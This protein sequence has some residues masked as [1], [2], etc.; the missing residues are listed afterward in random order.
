MP[1]RKM[2][3]MRAL[4][5]AKQMRAQNRMEMGDP[6]DRS[7]MEGFDPVPG[8]TPRGYMGSDSVPISQLSQAELNR[9][10]ISRRGSDEALRRMESSAAFPESD[11]MTGMTDSEAFPESDRTY[12]DRVKARAQ[13]LQSGKSMFDPKLLESIRGSTD[14]GNAFAETTAM[15][16]PERFDARDSLDD[17]PGLFNRALNKANEIFQM[18]GSVPSGI[19]R[20]IGKLDALMNTKKSMEAADDR[21]LEMSMLNPLQSGF[22]GRMRGVRQSLRDASGDRLME[23]RFA[24][25]VKA[26]SQLP[27]M[28]E[29]MIARDKLRGELEDGFIDRQ[30]QF[31]PSMPI[32]EGGEDEIEP[33]MEKFDSRHKNRLLRD[34]GE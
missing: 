20:E 18:T 21:A 5:M 6:K 22:G 28:E 29:M 10:G 3:P 25:R 4:Q 7:E 31:Q 32:I 9:L 33:A 13:S 2:D 27:S 26:M 23:A 11:P 14:Y 12:F 8:M 30:V 1:G 24:D 17:V 16:S 19:S 15:S 34:A